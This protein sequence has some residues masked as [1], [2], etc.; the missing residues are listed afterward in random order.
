MEEILMTN[1]GWERIKAK[2]EAAIKALQMELN[3]LKEVGLSVGMEDFID[4]ANSNGDKLKQQAEKIVKGNASIFKL[5][6]AK[7]KFIEE[8][9]IPLNDLIADT[10]NNLTSIL[11]LNSSYPLQIEAFAITKGCITFSDEWLADL[12]ES[13]TIRK[14]ERRVEA[15]RLIEEAKAAINNLNDF[16]KGNPYIS[17]GITSSEDDRRCL[18]YLNDYGTLIE[19]PEVLEYI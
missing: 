14:T 10:K 6:G 18:C 8:N 3:N 1:P 17:I 5:P 11:A 12:K 4:L 16:V 13:H 9:I 2:H 19:C 15:L 7:A